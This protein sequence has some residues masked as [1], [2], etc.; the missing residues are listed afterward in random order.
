MIGIYKI[1]NLI[2]GKIYIGQSVNINK[3][4]NDEKRRAFDTTDKSYEYPLN[5][6]IRKYG[7]ENFSFEIQEECTRENLNEREKYWIHYYDSFFNGYNQ[8]LGGEKNS[9]VQPKENVIGIIKDLK[10]TNL[11]HKDIAEKWNCSVEMVQGIN[12][13]RYWHLDYES[14]PLQIKKVEKKVYFCKDCGKEISK[15]AEYCVQCYCLNN[16]KVKRPSRNELKDLIRTKSFLEIGRIYQVSDNSIR[17]WCKAE[18]LPY[19]KTKIKSYS[20]EEWLEI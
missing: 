11:Y 2:N 7:I 12:T 14:Y 3:R 13:G 18:N 8:T 15:G 20:D 9:I 4:W 17:N 1:T 16:R 6:A 5:R 10:Q 19:Q